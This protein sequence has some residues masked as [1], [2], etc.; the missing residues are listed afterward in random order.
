MLHGVLRGAM[1]TPSRGVPDSKAGATNLPQVDEVVREV[2]AEL[3]VAPQ[4]RAELHNSLLYEAGGHFQKHRDS[5]KAR[6]M[7]G[8]L[9]VTLPARHEGGQLTVYHDGKKIEF[10]SNGDAGAIAPRWCA[11]YADCEH[12][13]APVISGYRLSHLQFVSY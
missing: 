9:V 10:S 8:T 13:L 7:F 11:F 6:G 5:E 4:V 2:R 12:V 3:G 1:I